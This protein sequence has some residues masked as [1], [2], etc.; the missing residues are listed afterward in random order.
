M[1]ACQQKMVPL[2]PQAGRN[3]SC[4]RHHAAV[5]T[6]AHTLFH[7]LSSTDN[8]WETADAS[9]CRMHAMINVLYCAYIKAKH[10]PVKAHKT[11]RTGS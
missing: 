3:G 9:E 10:T 7:S 1:L 8:L 2:K 6:N 5:A 11:T 4:Q